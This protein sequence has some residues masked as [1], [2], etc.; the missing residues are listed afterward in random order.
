MTLCIE[1]MLMTKSDK[2]YIDKNNHW[3]VYSKNHQLTCHCEH[4]IL[5]TKNGPEILTA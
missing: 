1:P 3:T 4:M 5:I 2:Y